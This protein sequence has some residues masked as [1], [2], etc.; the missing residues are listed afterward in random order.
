MLTQ[1]E[2]RIKW[3]EHDLRKLNALEPTHGFAYVRFVNGVS[4]RDALAERHVIAGQVVIATPAYTWNQRFTSEEDEYLRTYR[5]RPSFQTAADLFDRAAD[6]LP[7]VVMLDIMRQF[8]ALTLYGLARHSVHRHL[9]RLNRTLSIGHEI[10]EVKFSLDDIRTMLRVYDW[11]QEIYNLTIDGRALTPYAR[12][13]ICDRMIE[14]IGGQLKSL[15]LR[16]TIVYSGSFDRIKRLLLLVHSLDITLDFSFDYNLF[17]GAWPFLRTLL[18]RTSG[19][20]DLPEHPAEVRSFPMLQNMSI[21]TGYGLDSNLIER[22]AVCCPNIR[23]L[24]IANFGDAYVDLSQR[25]A[26]IT[27][28]VPIHRF[29]RLTTLHLASN[30]DALNDTTLHNIFNVTTLTDLTLEFT[31]SP[32]SPRL[33]EFIEKLQTIGDRLHNLRQLRL[34][35]IPLED[36]DMI[37]IIQG[38]SH[39]TNY[40]LNECVQLQLNSGLIE[41]ILNVRRILFPP[42]NPIICIN[43]LC[44]TID[45]QETLDVSCPYEL[46]FANDFKLK[47]VH[48]IR[49]YRLSAAQR[50]E[51][52]YWWNTPTI[53]ESTQNMNKKEVYMYEQSKQ[54]DLIVTWR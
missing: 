12:G 1:V 29:E 51:T 48:F 40:C 11:G 23:T 10:S 5:P 38:A 14:Y 52:F 3:F 45:D 7:V 20:V 21:I 36:N 24:L 18:I 15:K 13:N 49:Y 22:L 41:G 4:A 25:N 33:R 26:E 54:Q 17:N 2:K 8:D 16:H 37:A 19:L 34:S 39:I 43:I 30:T 42:P 27:N 44:N 6:N 28:F 53:S 50:L 47:P 32:E 46:V 35:H 31:S 9:F